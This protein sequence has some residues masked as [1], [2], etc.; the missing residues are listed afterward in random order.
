MLPSDERVAEHKELAS[1]G[2]LSRVLD[3][4]IRIPGTSMR[5]GLD[6]ILGLIPGLGD[7]AGALGSGY[8]LVRAA[9]LGAARSTLLRMAGNIG[10]D[11]VAGTVPMFGDLF[12]FGWKA[13]ERNMAL[14]RAHL[15]APEQRRKADHSFVVLLVVGLG[16][17]FLLCVGLSLWLFAWLLQTLIGS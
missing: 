4:A 7:W 16:L 12:D 6:P 8:I 10:V 13:N 5:I 14:L 15:E 11:L 9:G 17:L 3:G 1:L 2:R